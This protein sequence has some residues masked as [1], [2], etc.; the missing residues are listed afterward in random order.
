MFRPFASFMAALTAFGIASCATSFAPNY[1]LSFEGYPVPV[2]LNAK[3]AAP[4]G[5]RVMSA[6]VSRSAVA[7]SATAFG[8]STS[9]AG[10]VQTTTSWNA[11]ATSSYSAIDEASPISLKL[12][13][14]L[15][16]ADT[17]ITLTHIELQDLSF[18]LFGAA[19][20]VTEF[21][22]SAIGDGGVK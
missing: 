11:T 20:F 16:K 3:A 5:D 8:T 15:D 19:A 1:E 21:S 7:A 10:G 13:A 22:V 4:S 14:Q 18:F 6:K 9:A 12:A 17:S 2:L